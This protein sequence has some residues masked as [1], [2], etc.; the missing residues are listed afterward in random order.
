MERNLKMKKTL[1][2]AFILAATIGA[3]SPAMAQER[4]WE[5]WESIVWT[6]S[7]ETFQTPHHVG[8]TTCD[9]AESEFTI[10]KSFNDGSADFSFKYAPGLINKYG[11]RDSWEAINFTS[12]PTAAHD[13]YPVTDVQDEVSDGPVKTYG[14]CQI[15]GATLRCVSGGG[16][17]KITIVYHLISLKQHL[18]CAV[19][20]GGSAD[21]SCFKDIPAAEARAAAAN[22]RG[23]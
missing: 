10:I 22:P 5:K 4:P 8:F 1:K 17:N 2:L 18:L 3:A 11:S 21:D 20:D 6:A 9:G 12:G 19:D 16:D 7:C 13:F 23:H 15:S 14:A